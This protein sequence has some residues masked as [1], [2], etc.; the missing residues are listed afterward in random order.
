MEL[1]EKT[2]ESEILFEGKVITVKKDKVMLE[3]GNETFREIVMHHGGVCVIPI[4]DDGMTYVVK[5]YRYAYQKVLT[6]FPA[7]KLEKDENPILAAH[8]ELEEEI[9]M[10]AQELINLGEI[11]PS[12]GYLNEIIHIYLARGLVKTKQNLDDDEFLNVEKLPF[13]QLEQQVLS[14]EIKDA[15][16]IIGMFKAKI[17]MAK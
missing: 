6:E 16:T 11:Y 12:C 2:L 5:Q 4:D 17:I 8:R 9:G 3:N 15:K 1:T 14:G 10:K 7:G 13:A